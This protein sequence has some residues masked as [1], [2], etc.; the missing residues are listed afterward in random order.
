MKILKWFQILIAIQFISCASTNFICRSQVEDLSSIQLL[1]KN[2]SKQML[3]TLTSDKTEFGTL[4]SVSDSSISA[5]VDSSQFEYNFTQIK[6]LSFKSRTKGAFQGLFL[7]MSYSFIGG[8]L[9]G[10]AITPRC[11]EGDWLCFS[12]GQVGLAIGTILTPFGMLIGTPIGIYKSSRQRFIFIDS[13]EQAKGYVNNGK[14]TY[15]IWRKNKGR[16]SR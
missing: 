13:P 14:T 2:I 1:H 8:F 6:E 5:L 16:Q 10:A 7:G 3:I 11:K 12:P 4:I 15:R 9:V